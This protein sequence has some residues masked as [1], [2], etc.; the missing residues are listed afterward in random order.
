MQ[1]LKH[2]Y[3]NLKLN[4]IHTLGKFLFLVFL[5]TAAF[6]LIDSL[7]SF[8]REIEVSR[9]SY[10]KQVL[11]I[12]KTKEAA[13]QLTIKELKRF[14]E[15]NYL[16]SVA[17]EGNIFFGPTQDIENETTPAET[18]VSEYN[19]VNLLGFESKQLEQELKN[20]LT[21]G[22]YL[23]SNNECLIS[24]N[25]SKMNKLSIGD[26]AVFQSN[27]H[28][29]L[30]T[31]KGIYEQLENLYAI[32]EIY[33][34]TEA[35]TQISQQ[36]SK[37][38]QWSAVYLLKD[39]NQLSDF[40]AELKKKGLS[41]QYLVE[42]NA[43]AY[44]NE[45]V[46]LKQG[47]QQ[48]KSYLLTLS[49]FGGI[50][51][52]WLTLLEKNKRQSAVGYL[53][54]LRVKKA[55]QLIACVV[56]NFL[57]VLAAALISTVLSLFLAPVIGDLLLTSAAGKAASGSSSFSLST[58]MV[59]YTDVDEPISEAVILVSIAAEKI[60]FFLAALMLSCGYGLYTI[61]RFQ[62]RNRLLKGELK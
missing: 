7:K 32:E 54:T 26:T 12:P 45:V 21:A 2:A 33:T 49:I 18:V 13:N 17:V 28:E 11:I 24:S 40:T 61:G 44:N 6:S 31:V 57:L 47:L 39:K 14:G 34:T 62:L 41:D 58:E 48:A 16:S 46:W 1:S 20:K 30:L 51:L 5:L 60:W 4:K 22:T 37:E 10:S 15:S 35:L 56:E 3:F 52:Y 59:V 36:L 23:L 8:D 55:K 27:G 9:S 43:E 50:S 29:I 25:Y 42:S 53:T 38:V 19:S